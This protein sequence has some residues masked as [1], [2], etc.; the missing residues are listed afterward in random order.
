MWPRTWERDAGQQRQAN[1]GCASGLASLCRLLSL[2][3]TPLWAN[4]SCYDGPEQMEWALVVGNGPNK[5]T[6]N[7]IR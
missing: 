7:K 3:P 2:G 6:Q 1:V 4:G 5:N